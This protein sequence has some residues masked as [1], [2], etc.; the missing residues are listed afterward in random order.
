M[1][2]SNLQNSIVSFQQ[3]AKEVG[4]EIVNANNLSDDQLKVLNDRLMLTERQ[5]LSKE[6]LPKRPYYKH[7]VQAPG[8]I[9]IIYN[10]YW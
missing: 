9:I 5:F 7:V 4:E 8:K 3:A 2:L 10:D 1:D 6:G